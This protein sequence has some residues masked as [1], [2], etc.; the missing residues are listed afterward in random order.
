M[1]ERSVLQQ[2]RR[3][4][5]DLSR[6]VA[7]RAA[8]EE[9][10]RMRWQTGSARAHR[11]YDLAAVQAE[12]TFEHVRIE[13]QTRHHHESAA[14]RTRTDALLVPAQKR[15]ERQVGIYAGR[16]TAIAGAAKQEYT[17]SVW[18]AE[19]LVESGES[20]IRNSFELVR[21]AVESKDRV[22]AQVRAGANALLEE[23]R[24]AALPEVEPA[25]QHASTPET[26]ES[27]L[28]ELEVTKL[29]AQYQSEIL[30][31]AVQPAWLRL[32]VVVIAVLIA[33]AAA[34]AAGWHYAGLER[35]Q[36]AYAG[37]AGALL[38][39]LL[40]W[41]GK[42]L[43]RRRIPAKARQLAGVLARGHALAQACMALAEAHRAQET[44][45]LH[46]RR[47][48]EMEKADKRLNAFKREVA[49]RTTVGLP[50]LRELHA[51]RLRRIRERHLQHQH[52]LDSQR[53]QT[54]AAAQAQRDA[55]IAA[56]T[57]TRDAA[58]AE[59]RR[60][61]AHERIIF[62]NSWKDG[63][64]RIHADVRDLQQF[65]AG[66]PDWDL[67]RHRE[68]GRIF[69]LPVAVSF[70]RVAVD[71]AALPGGLPQ[72]QDFQID[73]PARFDLPAV[74][75]FL[76]V[77]SL[78]LR[79]AAAERHRCIDLL[80]AVMLRIL[81]SL[82]PGKARFTII[83]PVGLGES[84][85]GFMHLADHEEALV[86]SKIWTEPR[87][88]EQ[89]L[90]DLTE[91]METVIQKYLRNEYDNIRDYNRQAGEIAEPLRILVF[92][93]FP[94]NL[95]EAAAKRLAS[96]ISSGPRCGVYT[97][98]AAD[99][100]AKLPSWVPVAELQ[101]AST[102]LEWDGS[103]WVCRDE[104]FEC[105]P[106]EVDAAP[107]ENLLTELVHAVGAAARDVNRVQVPFEAV[108]PQNGQLWSLSSA[109]EIRVPLGRSGAKKLQYMTLGRGTAQH[110]LVA[111]R[112]GSGKSTLFHV[113]IT[114]LGLW[115]S[116][117]EIEMYLVDFKKGVEFKTYAVHRL[118]HA[119]VVAVESEREFGISVLRRLD[120]ELTRRGTLFR[121]A[122]VQDMAGYRRELKKKRDEETKDG[123]RNAR[124]G[125]GSDSSSLHLSVS[126]SLPAAP[127]S[128]PRILLLVDEFQ[129]FF[130]ED[131]KIAQEASLLLDRLVRQGRAFG[132]HVVLGSQTLGGAYSIARSTIG[133]MAVRVALQCSE[134]DSY[135]IM[136]ED[137]AAPRLLSRPGEAIYNDASGMV[138]GNSP[139]QIVWLPDEKRDVYLEQI[140]QAIA[141]SA[142]PRPPAPVVFEGNIPANIAANHLLAAALKGKAL[143]GPASPPTAWLGE[144]ISIKDPTS[145]AFK[146][147]SGSNLLIVGQQEDVLPAMLLAI[148]LGLAAPRG[149]DP[150]PQFYLLDALGDDMTGAAL[151]RQTAQELSTAGG[152]LRD[153]A[154]VLA[155][156]AEELT[157][158]ESQQASAAP[159]SPP[160]FLIVDALH[161]YR[162]LRKSDD[163]SFS[164]DDQPQTPA[165]VFARIVRDGPA[166]GI[167]T[168]AWVDTVNNLERTLE[169][170]LLREFENRALFQ[171]SGT[172]S[173]H[174]IES[175]AAASLGRYRALLYREELGAVEKFRPYALPSPEWVATAVAALRAPIS[176]T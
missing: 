72:D 120:A 136:S 145:I 74:L 40:L 116:P 19:T 128:L 172:D 71:M 104:D 153:A 110:A 115:Y 173:T 21:K 92:A 68:F 52:E 171:M 66:F 77:G 17:E 63:M 76:D 99:S 154:A 130:I 70:G 65:A 164:T 5:R 158:R 23:Y 37:A 152:G 79:A 135:L 139:F 1:P 97:L 58:L 54:V 126:S 122:G 85:A 61:D 35:L 43:A 143:P 174:L 9:S 22:L 14:L 123:E 31:R 151:F 44:A 93:D 46:A 162:D 73:G 16:S 3:L 134:A 109:E 36:V 159:G 89:R 150:A 12:H 105:W 78:F 80:N 149:S 45:E 113:L 98:I 131:D 51:R 137:N 95:N 41:I 107:D 166:H 13:A 155:P 90:S 4:L 28:K 119:R 15:M 86:S 161:R 133:Q 160:I 169:R 59:L 11:A 32:P 27:C 102:S 62:V 82:P 170:N 114:S 91:H 69:E 168:I 20:K 26:R 100:R 108:A 75:D 55:A 175:P 64:A 103:R 142:Q 165:Q 39:A 127:P 42:R 138:E 163:Y 56:A 111:G 157:L 106:L 147:Q 96:I 84:F 117:D 7:D 2:E 94:A 34:G 6:L 125:N 112:T 10:L 38:V 53:D 24:F 101:R 57:D 18:L 81:T 118:P 8:G 67:L 30:G 33:A 132:M 167:H 25:E 176:P 148:M 144:A 124:Q 146:R 87:H 156:I 48:Q 88:I 129:E 49:R 83:D 60:L 29:S 47:T 140:E 121:D 141:A 50:R